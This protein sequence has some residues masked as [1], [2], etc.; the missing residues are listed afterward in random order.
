MVATFPG[1]THGL[2][3]LTV[4]LLDDFHVTAVEFG[5]INLWASL[6]GAAFCLP[7]GWLIDRHGLR[8][9]LAAVVIGL[10]ASVLA[11]TSAM[12]VPALAVTITLTRGFGQSALS[13]VSLAVV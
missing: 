9:V 11:M 5:Q 3:L 2:G 1:R 4:P 6:V 10:G 12:T 8:P 13:V 7:C